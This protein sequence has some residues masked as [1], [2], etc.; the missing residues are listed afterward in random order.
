MEGPNLLGDLLKA[1]VADRPGEL[2]I[3][4]HTVT[5]HASPFAS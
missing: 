1:R 2:V 5:G 4:D 3:A